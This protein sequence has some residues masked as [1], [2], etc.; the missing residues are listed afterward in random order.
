MIIL[1]LFYLLKA[2]SFTLDNW[3]DEVF[4]GAKTS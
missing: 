1:V 3:T 4:A 2:L